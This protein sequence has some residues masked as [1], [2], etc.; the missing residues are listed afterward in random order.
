[1][2]AEQIQQLIQNQMPDAIVSVNGNEGKFTAEVISE[3]FAGLPL[4]KRHKQV[5][6]GVQDE[7]ASGALHALSIVAKTP[8]EAASTGE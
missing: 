7:I 5:Y 2:N 6:A 3:S 8:Q 4:I 1:M